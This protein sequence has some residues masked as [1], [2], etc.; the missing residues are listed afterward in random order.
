MQEV[1]VEAKTKEAEVTVEQMARAVRV[2]ALRD[3]LEDARA[4]SQVGFRNVI[5]KESGIWGVDPGVLG[6]IQVSAFWS[7]L[8][9]G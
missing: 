5:G 9:A 2:G 6:Y 4:T 7:S 8:A 1:E 3:K